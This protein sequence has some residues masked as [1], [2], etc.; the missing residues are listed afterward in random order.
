MFM[1]TEWRRSAILNETDFQNHEEHALGVSSLAA[2]DEEGDW[3]LKSAARGAYTPLSAY[4]MMAF[5]FLCMPC[6]AVAIATR[7]EF[8]S[9]K[10]FGVAFAYQSALAWTV[11]LLIYQGGRLLGLGG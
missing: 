5:V 11:A 10:W 3:P 6:V 1:L 8:G 4:A 2:E 9:W 7:Q